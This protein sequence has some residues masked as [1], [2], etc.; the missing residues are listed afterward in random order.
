MTSAAAAQPSMFAVFRKRNFTLL[1]LSQLISTS[2]SALTD[3]AAGILIY[4]ETGSA[5][6]VGLMLAATAL[7]ALVVGLVAGVFV[8]RYD[9]KKIMIVSCLLRAVLVASIPAAVAININLLY[10][11]V[12]INAA[13]AQ[14]FDPAQESVIP[15]VA[16]DEELAAAN[17]FLS[18]S[19]FGSTAI[20][21]AGAGLLA[22]LASIEFAFYFDAVTFLVS[23][24]LI[25]FVVV[26]PIEVEEDTNV[27]VV[28]N[29][30]R[31]G[32][33]YMANLPILRNSF[34]SGVPAYFSFGLWNVLLLPFAITALNATEFEYGLQ[35]GLTS[36]G[37][38]VGSLF[39]AKYTDRLR[40]GQW[41]VIG[42]LGMGVMGVAYGLVSSIPLAI[43]LVTVSGFLNAPAA[44]ARRLIL[45]RNS[46]REMRGRVFSTFGVLR[47]VIFLIGMF[48]AGLA[49]F[50][51]IRLLVVIS[52]VILIGTGIWTQFLPGLG[53]PAAEWR[54]AMQRLRTATAAPAIPSRPFLPDDLG[55]LIGVIPAFGV[56]GDNERRVL[57]SS[58][59]IREVPAGTTVVAAG[60]K[61]D[62]AFAILT[63]RAVAG[64]PIE[65]GEYRALSTMLEGDVFGEIAALTGSTRT[66]N[67]VA[68]AD[69]TLVEIPGPALR[70]LM[71]VPEISDIILPK[72]TER[73]ARTTT[74][75]LPRLAGVDQAALRDL[76]KVRPSSGQ[77][78]PV[79]GPEGVL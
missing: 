58:A 34:L 47:D 9:R 74:A 7:P 27:R 30:L 51:D 45:Q 55:T 2:G 29:G 39:M 3:L 17:S 67:V 33:R 22:S 37:F 11:I 18:I 26:R 63:G 53:E 56:L 13:I 35:E 5:L 4:R 68:D 46:P 6:A 49:D 65:G 42:M 50:V 57:L 12:F 40:E 36:V 75:D 10:V 32:F 19:S 15:D 23:A 20:G 14:F 71:A 66:A 44:I 48:A 31:D 70:S 78:T 64:T 41:I 38:V 62:S 79:T 72:M 61:G 43:L 52:G 28:I 76:R 8:D 25:L 69:S 60:E 1:W 16:T 24:A 77:T 54:Q 59:R 21:F 73:L